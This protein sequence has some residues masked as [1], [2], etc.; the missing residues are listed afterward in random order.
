[1][2]DLYIVDQDYHANIKDSYAREK[3]YVTPQQQPGFL[4]TALYFS[5]VQSQPYCPVDN[6][7]LQD[8]VR[9]QM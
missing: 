2:I 5:T 7:L 4:G 9:K 8:Y 1:M 6:T 3:S